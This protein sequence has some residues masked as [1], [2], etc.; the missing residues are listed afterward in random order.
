MASEEL[1]SW[2]LNSQRLSRESIF[3]LDR[4]MLITVSLGQKFVRVVA[5]DVTDEKIFVAES[6]GVEMA[7]KS[8]DTHGLEVCNEF[9][10]MP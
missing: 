9:Q 4:S 6:Y 2:L 8:D 10:E 5:I 1:A 7:I 3:Y